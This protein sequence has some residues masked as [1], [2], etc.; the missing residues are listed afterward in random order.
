MCVQIPKRDTRARRIPV[1][2]G[3]N[4]DPGSVGIPKPMRNEDIDRM[5]PAQRRQRWNE[6]LPKCLE[7]ILHIPFP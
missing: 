3:K 1:P 5:I 4:P 7:I 6:N 2:K